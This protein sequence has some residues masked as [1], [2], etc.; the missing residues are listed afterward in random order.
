MKKT[1][2]L[3]PMLSL[4]AFTIPSS[5]KQ[6]PNTLSA[7][8][9]KEGFKLLFDGTSLNGWH[10]YGEK[11]VP[12]SWRIK[13]GG[14]ELD[15]DAK[16]RKGGDLVSNEAYS[17]FDL[18]LEWKISKNGNSGILFYVQDDPAKYKATYFTGPEM[19]VLDNDGH[20]DGKI[21]KHRAG[22]L[23]DLIKSSSEPVKPVGEWNQVEIISKNGD[24]KLFLNGVNVVHTTLW[25][26]NWKKMVAGSK[27]KQWHDF[28]TSKSGHIALQDHGNAVWY[29]NVRI[30]KL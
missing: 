25:D 4:L 18:K 2:L 13:G 29:R 8:E 14:L 12:D 17:D 7:A 20:P 11:S 26:D 16:D 21:L 6:E 1:Y 23:Y 5:M 10:T 3:V 9:K 15:A 24:L 30:R 27:F 22:D 28:G 19:Q